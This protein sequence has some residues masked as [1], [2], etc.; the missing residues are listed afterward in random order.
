MKFNRLSDSQI[1]NRMNLL[2]PNIF[3]NE[4]MNAELYLS[5]LIR[6]EDFEEMWVSVCFYE[7]MLKDY[8]IT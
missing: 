5:F 4:L 7:Q 1:F 3:I 2:I 8:G 6:W